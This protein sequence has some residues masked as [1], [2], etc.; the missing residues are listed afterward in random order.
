M[1]QLSMMCSWQSGKCGCNITDKS[2]YLYNACHEK[3]AAGN[4]AICSWATKDLDCP[5]KGC[6]ALEIT[7]PKGFTPDDATD[8]HRPAP[9]LFTFDPKYLTNW[10]VPFNDESSSIAGQ[11]CTYVEPST[12]QC[13]P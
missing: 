8:H 10:N 1:S 2:N 11:Q 4:D 3:N 12:A 9:S 6:P 7:F 5:E 13:A